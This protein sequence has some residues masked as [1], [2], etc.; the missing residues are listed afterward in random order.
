MVLG[1]CVRSRAQVAVECRL[2]REPETLALTHLVF[3]DPPGKT[4]FVLTVC[5]G[6]APVPALPQIHAD[7]VQLAF[8]MHAENG[9]LGCLQ[10]IFTL[11]Q[12]GSLEKLDHRR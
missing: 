4:E 8:D 6:G 7:L 5:R 11:G 2:K 3:A 12:L 1:T 10:M 9:K